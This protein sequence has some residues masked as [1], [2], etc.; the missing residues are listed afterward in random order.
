MEPLWRRTNLIMPSMELK[1]TV[2]T[3]PLYCPT[4]GRLYLQ[5]AGNL[6]YIECKCSRCKTRFTVRDGAIIA[7]QS[8]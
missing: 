3:F 2:R 8:T 7:S 4:C 6:E 5:F 1:T